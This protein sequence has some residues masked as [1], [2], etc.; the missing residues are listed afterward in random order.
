MNL[1]TPWLESELT[2]R[3]TANAQYLISLYLTPLGEDTAKWLHW[4]WDKY[5]R[6]LPLQSATFQFS[7]KVKLIINVDNAYAV[8]LSG[9]KQAIKALC[10]DDIPLVRV[11]EWKHRASKNKNGGLVYRWSYC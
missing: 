4:H 6:G 2:E 9:Q 1:V 5:P 3:M 8:S 11:K 7:G 10:T